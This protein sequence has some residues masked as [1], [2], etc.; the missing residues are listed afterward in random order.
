MSGLPPDA[1]PDSEFDAHAAL[2]SGRRDLADY[3]EQL[4]LRDWSRPSLCDGWTITDVVAHLT[5]S[6]T[7]T[8]RLLIIGM[9]RNLG[10]FDRWN[11]TSARH[12]AQHHTPAEL[13]ALLREHADSRHHSPGSSHLDQLLDLLVH[14]Q[15]IRRPGRVRSAPT[16]RRRRHRR[17]DRTSLWHRLRDPG[18]LR[19]RQP[20]RTDAQHRRVIRPVAPA[21]TKE[22]P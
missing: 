6:T 17:A 2:R 18:S 3:L 8:W 21:S 14:S 12:H 1:E 10:N 15:D 22:Q 16:T 20:Y 19:Q 9:V 7:E 13:V 5:L 4:D 11:A